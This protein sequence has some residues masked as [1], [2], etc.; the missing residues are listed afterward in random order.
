[1]RARAGA[2]VVVCFP[3]SAGTVN[4]WLRFWRLRDDEVVFRPDG[5]VEL[6]LVGYVRLRLHP[7]WAPDAAHMAGLFGLTAED[8]VEQGDGWVLVPVPNGAMAVREGRVLLWCLDFVPR[9][10]ELEEMVLGTRYRQLHRFLEETER[11][12]R[13]VGY[14]LGEEGELLYG[15]VVQGR[16][17]RHQRVVLPARLLSPAEALGMELPAAP[18]VEWATPAA[19]E[20]APEREE[21]LQEREGMVLPEEAAPVREEAPAAGPEGESVGLAWP[22]RPPPAEERRER[23]SPLR[24]AAGAIVRA[25]ASLAVRPSGPEERGE[26]QVLTDYL[27]V[28]GGVRTLLW[29]LRQE[30][31][32]ARGAPA[33]WAQGQ[34]CGGVIELEREMGEEAF[35]QALSRATRSL[36][37]GGIEARR[38]GPRL[39]QLGV[40]PLPAPRPEAAAVRLAL[41]PIGRQERAEGV[42]VT[43][44]DLGSPGGL[45]LEAA[46]AEEGRWLSWWVTAAGL[47]LPGLAV[48]AQD[49]APVVGAGRR[50]EGSGGVVA[51]LYE[52]VVARFEEPR[53]RAP[54]LAVMRQPEERDRE[55]LATLAARG[56]EVGCYVV[57]LGETGSALLPA[58]VRAA[59]GLVEAMV[60]GGRAR[61]LPP[62]VEAGGEGQPAPPA[63][64]GA[65]P[66][67]AAP[68]EEAGVE[69]MPMEEALGKKATPGGLGGRALA[70][71][72]AEEEAPME[73]AAGE[74]T[75]PVGPEVK[76]AGAGG[77]AEGEA[78][79]EEEQEAGPEAAGEGQLLP[80]GPVRSPVVVRV[81]GPFS[82]SLET[83]RQSAREVLSL[84][85]LRQGEMAA[86]EAAA[87]LE[88][89]KAGGEVGRSYALNR[90]H[91]AVQDLRAACERAGV[92]KEV[93]RI[94]RAGRVALV[95]DWVWCDLWEAQEL[96]EAFR[97]EGLGH[98]GA[99]RLAEL[100]RGPVLEGEVFPWAE[101]EAQRV[102]RPLWRGLVEAAERLLRQERYEE[103]CLLAEAARRLEPLEERP[104]RTQLRALMALGRRAQAQQ[105]V[106][107]HVRQ[108]RQLLEDEEVELEEETQQL[109]RLLEEE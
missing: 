94:T 67:R 15:G 40:F 33:V 54:V 108:L 4:D 7:T 31:V 25:A 10:D 61:L 1:M 38:V 81:L 27:Q 16:I 102:G 58:W 66:A 78:E 97:Q 92:P 21:A 32:P 87:M 70:R 105:A 17:P 13:R 86:D 72:A 60:A 5:R 96:L 91:N 14:R 101:G 104:L 39:Y 45:L 35:R 74:G 46:P 68:G 75:A 65:A 73:E 9:L 56:P 88:M 28:V 8:V 26:G 20:A 93:F 53:E 59:E 95:R 106:R 18:P 100:V 90:L 84:L 22:E 89:G 41:V 42:W 6:P 107:A 30:G 23:A 99:A 48:W 71:E 55:L 79:G 51:A 29:A 69:S 24:R 80:P 44:A 37:L 52:E 57:V 62:E 19:Q 85:A 11:Y 36:S 3:P 63:A 2:G 76:E 49:G 103:A 64:P 34:L 43:L 109:V 12:R 82:C 83:R 98:E 50:M 47:S 77:E